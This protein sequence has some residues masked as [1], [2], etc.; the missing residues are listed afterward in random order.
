[1]LLSAIVESW[2][3]LVILK[4]DGHRVPDVNEIEAH[5]SG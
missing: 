2:E 5:P 4:V 3:Q 1:V